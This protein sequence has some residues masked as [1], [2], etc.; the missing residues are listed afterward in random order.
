MNE[1]KAYVV[2]T[3]MDGVAEGMVELD[4]IRLEGEEVYLKHEADEEIDF[5]KKASHDHYERWFNLNKQY[6]GWLGKVVR[7]ERA[8]REL[9]RQKYKRCLAMAKVC[10]LKY[11]RYENYLM[12]LCASN[13]TI[14]AYKFR[15]DIYDKWEKRWLEYA[16]KFKHNSQ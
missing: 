14:A 7:C 1:L 3:P 12:K 10:Y 8:E 16:K 9:R 13:A 11:V 2:Y 15:R 5:W 4:S 6:E